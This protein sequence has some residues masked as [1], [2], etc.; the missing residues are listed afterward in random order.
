MSNNLF[1]PIF[2]IPANLMELEESIAREFSASNKQVPVA[3]YKTI[4]PN[5]HDLLEGFVYVQGC[6]AKDSCLLSFCYVEEPVRERGE[7]DLPYSAA[8]STEGNRDFLLLVARAMKNFGARVLYDD[9]HYL[10]EV[11]TRNLT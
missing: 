1:V 7:L 6:A 5:T 11:D 2:R 10:G 4:K 8:I 9:S 3:W